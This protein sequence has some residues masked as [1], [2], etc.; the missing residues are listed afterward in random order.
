MANKFN[1]KKIST[2]DGIFDSK[3]EYNRWLELKRMQDE[4]TITDLQRQV[5]Y[6]L[7]PKQM[8]NGKVIERACTYTADFVYRFMGDLIVE[9]VK[10]YR[11]G[12]HYNVFTI[13]R[14]LMLWIHN[15][16]ISE[17]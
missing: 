13:K 5:K 11:K 1:T 6:E 7:I 12:A 3:K 10:G 9:D 17:V 15:I 4:G 2:D 8:I 14:K 16:R